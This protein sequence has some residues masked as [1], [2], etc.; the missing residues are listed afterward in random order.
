MHARIAC[1]FQRR[2]SELDYSVQRRIYRGM[3][4]P[5][6][7]VTVAAFYRFAALPDF[8]S[9]RQPLLDV[10]NAAG[11]SGTILLA[12]EGINGT[13]AGPKPGI[14]AV[15]DQIRNLPGCAELDLKWSAARVNPFYRM[16]V[17]L[18]REIVTMGLAD[19]DPATS[20]G[21]HVEPE[22][23]N[24]LISDPDIVVI[25]TRNAYEVGIGSFE[26]AINPKTSSF[27]EFPNWLE[28]RADE[29]RSTKVAMF[30]TGGIRCEKAT[31]YAKKLGFIDVFHL[32]GG[33]L[34]YLETIPEAESLW[35]GECFVFDKRVSVGHDLA[36]GKYETC[37]A[38]RTPLSASDLQSPHHVTGVSC[39][40]CH[41]LRSDS[42]RRRYRERQRQIERAEARGAEHLGTAAQR[43]PDSRLE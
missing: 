13:I 27:R 40:H 31:A 29:L 38:C 37:H 4:G 15:I 20:A 25:D 30:C 10:C 34:N 9:Y 18:K 26:N 8:S 17:R 2:M 22:D 39:R 7:D 33:I 5:K 1:H 11:V 16:K 23:W 24:D 19:I 35:R 36:P 21:Q 3:N 32:K 6:D 41:D 28:S 43:G 12:G 14:Q 42:Q